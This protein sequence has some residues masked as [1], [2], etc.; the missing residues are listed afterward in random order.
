MSL[1]FSILK[2]GDLW[3]F[4]PKSSPAIFELINGT[5]KI[6]QKYAD[7]IYKDNKILKRIRPQKRIDPYRKFF[8]SQALREYVGSMRL[9]T[10]GLQVPNPL[11]YGIN[12]SPFGPYESVLLMEYIPNIGT[13]REVLENKADS[14]T[15]KNLLN[16]L[17]NDLKKMINEGVFHKDAHLGN[18]LVSKDYNIF[19]IDNDISTLK[20]SGDIDRLLKKFTNNTLISEKEKKTYLSTTDTCSI[21]GYSYD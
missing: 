10:I 19:W 6:H 17:G 13:L 5:P 1:R 9:R 18:I 2:C 11:G 15:R 12:L 14:T 20:K 21:K 16:Q 8:R 4:H 7:L 3:W